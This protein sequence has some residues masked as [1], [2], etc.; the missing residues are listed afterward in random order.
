[1]YNK[2]K[3]YICFKQRYKLSKLFIGLYPVVGWRIGKELIY[4]AEGSSSDTGILI[5][6]AKSIGNSLALNCFI[7]Q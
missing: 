6:W 4:V 1:M 2:L 7:K 3:K 5:E